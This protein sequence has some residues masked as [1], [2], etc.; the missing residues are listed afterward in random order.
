MRDLFALVAAAVVLAACSETPT[1]PTVA[2]ADL[3]L[4]NETLYCPVPFTAVVTKLEPPHEADHNLDGTVCELLIVTEGGDA[5]MFSYVDNNVPVQLGY[6]PEGFDLIFYK[7]I[8]GEPNIDRNGD[9]RV[10]TATRPNGNVVVIDNRFEVEKGGT[11][12]PKEEEVITK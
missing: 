4:A 5:K 12:P 6:C 9:I 3:D 1:D 8:A 10:C 2:P 7:Q 11:E